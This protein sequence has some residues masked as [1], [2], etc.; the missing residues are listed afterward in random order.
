MSNSLGALTVLLGLDASEYVRGLTKAEAQAK[1]FAANTRSAI[2]EVG[3]V[4]GG[5]ELGRV[6][7]E[8]TKAIVEEAS[9]LQNL[10][11]SL[12][13]SVEQLSRLN[14]QSKIAGTDF[15]TLQQA[16]LKLAA[17]MAGA[18]DES[19][20][21]KEALKILG[22]TTKDPVQALE[23]VAVKL[24]TYAD[25]VN[26]VGLAQALFGKQGPAFLSTLKD[27]AELQDVGA[28]VTAKQAAE[29]QALEQAMRRLSVESEGFKNLI[30]SGL[31]PA[32]RDMVS[33]FSEGIKVAGGFGQALRL[34][35]QIDT[36]DLA[37]ETQRIAAAIEHAQEVIARNKAL[38]G[39]GDLFGGDKAVA[40][41]N[42]Q[43]RFLQAIARERG[44]ASISPLN[45]DARDFLA[46]RK[47][48]APNP[49][50]QG[51]GLKERTSEAQKYLEALQKQLEKTE[52][53][54]TVETFL[55][56][57]QL[58]RFKDI[59][60]AQKDAIFAVAQEIDDIKALTKEIED[61]KKAWEEETKAVLDNLKAQQQATK[62]A[63][64]SAQRA[65]EN[66]DALRDEIAI[67]LGG[68][69][70]REALEKQ[71]ADD[72]IQTKEEYLALRE[73]QGAREDELEAI[74]LEIDQLKERRELLNGKSLAIQLKA[75]AE[76]LQ[77]VKNLFSDALVNPLADFVTGTKSAKDAFKSFVDDVSRQLAK[78]ASQNVANAIFGGNSSSGPD[79][80]GW[81]AKLLGGFG[82]GGG[83][84][85]LPPGTIMDLGQFGG[86]GIGS[87]A[88]GST[89]WRGGATMVGENGP[90]LLD[91][92]A[93]ARVTPKNYGGGSSHN[94]NVSVAP[95]AG[96]SRQTAQ[97]F[98]V[99]VGSEIG[100][101]MKRA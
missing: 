41:L 77:Q 70:A 74:K 97:Q 87:L 25:G 92:P 86:S 47:P 14:N 83:G 8:N 5:L 31:V 91:L 33:Q 32:L 79:I 72:A 27:I 75:D 2:L 45:N 94:I 59:T 4:L 46:Q 69:H 63:L 16:A 3:K 21:V 49:P 67:I 56:E 53:L 82:G 88:S 64:D 76:A 96:M 71:R 62:G 90:E 19:T 78:I 23:E 93:G 80:F 48:E 85:G 60:H 20:R 15:A 44:L 22:V 84:G 68:E 52:E 38:F 18:D 29:A 54:T 57:L 9:A 99:Q 6:I 34:L 17:G 81:L 37:G 73:L 55:R 30:L 51:G 43:L 101:R 10:S 26:K 61:G 7:L 40:N 98:A 1:Q 42:T 50:S 35:G 11:G 95:P 100:R 89:Y 66:T 58:G 24:N 12:G 65:K 39:N 13:S 28:T 36:G